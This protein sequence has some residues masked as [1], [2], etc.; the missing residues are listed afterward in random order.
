MK[1]FL[2]RRGDNIDIW[3]EMELVRESTSYSMRVF[4]MKRVSGDPLTPTQEKAIKIGRWAA[5]MTGTIIG[6][7]DSLE[8]LICIAAMTKL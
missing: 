6:E 4:H 5:W 2:T 3:K 8:E 7:S 1:Y